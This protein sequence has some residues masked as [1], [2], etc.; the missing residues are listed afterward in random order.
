MVQGNGKGV[1]TLTE[2]AF[3]F[4]VWYGFYWMEQQ[5]QWHVKCRTNAVT[6]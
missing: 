1:F 3:Y 5:K 4:L 6:Y 2:V